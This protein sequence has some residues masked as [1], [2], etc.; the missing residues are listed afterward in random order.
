MFN[1]LNDAKFIPDPITRKL[2]ASISFDYESKDIKAIQEII[3]SIKY[4][5]TEHCL[6]LLEKKAGIITNK[7]IIDID[8]LL[9]LAISHRQE[10]AAMKLFELG[11]SFD[12]Y[13]NWFTVD[14]PLWSAIVTNQT[15]LVDWIL[16]NQKEKLK[17][18][19]A[20]KHALL[21]CIINGKNDSALKLLNSTIEFDVNDVTG[22]DNTVL[23]HALLQAKISPKL[24]KDLCKKGADVCK[25]D[26]AGKTALRLAL[27]KKNYKIIS[28]LLDTPNKAA[29]QDH[30]AILET[31]FL[32][33][34][35]SSDKYKTKVIKKLFEL[36]KTTPFITLEL[37]IETDKNYLTP[38]LMEKYDIEELIKALILCIKTDR[39]HT[40]LNLIDRLNKFKNLE[41]YSEDII[42]VL[43]LSIDKPKIA[44]RL[45]NSKFEFDSGEIDS[46]LYDA[47]LQH[48][49][50]NTLVKALY[51][52]G[53]NAHKPNNF[54]TPFQKAYKY[55]KYELLHV[56]NQ[57][58]T[59]IKREL[60]DN[61]EEEMKFPDVHIDPQKLQIDEAG[62]L[63]RSHYK[64]SPEDKDK[65]LILVNL[66]SCLYNIQ[67]GRL[68]DAYR[69][70]EQLLANME[71][72]PY[73]RKPN[74]LGGYNKTESLVKKSL[75]LMQTV[76]GKIDL[77]ELPQ[78]LKYNANSLTY[79][80]WSQEDKIAIS[81]IINMY[82]KDFKECGC[83]HGDMRAELL[84]SAYRFLRGSS[85][86]TQEILQHK[87]DTYHDMFFMFTSDTED[88]FREHLRLTPAKK[89]A[90]AALAQS[91]P[92]P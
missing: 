24:I 34:R 17:N 2:A 20:I 9:F 68:M 5:P 16:E 12:C 7:E 78:G 13:N 47:F 92:S 1:D 29:F 22:G 27:D 82:N 54:G 72:Y 75:G 4:H 66:Y 26:K 69:D 59:R 35:K 46:A 30:T 87:L 81:K 74:K 32:A 79:E 28:I 61:N 83:P 73:Y 86:I 6:K 38:E 77:E 88:L 36:N 48:K 53:A 18:S 23:H 84:F 52:R 70:R 14:Y 91:A 31:I 33:T 25:A 43:R 89:Q 37:I 80:N 63:I 64:D 65:F 62:R 49:I 19:K 41:F 60:Y 39:T 58:H 50:D 44:I 85:R 42:P 15:K 3:N 21:T 57:E 55:Q 8:Y 40:A 76:L 45:L 51:A 56:F 90:S 10:E 71:K 11:A 67:D